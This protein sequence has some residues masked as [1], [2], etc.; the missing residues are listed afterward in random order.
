MATDNVFL[1]TCK[2]FPC[3]LRLNQRGIPQP[4]VAREDVGAGVA[5]IVAWQSYH[6]KCE[7]GTSRNVI[8]RNT[9][10][11]TDAEHPQ[12]FRQEHDPP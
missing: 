12:S 6:K 3:K 1:L 9:N 10:V 8:S 7:R 2:G 11:R 4:A 5:P